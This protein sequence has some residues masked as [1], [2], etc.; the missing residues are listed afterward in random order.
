MCINLDVNVHVIG[1]QN[2]LEYTPEWKEWKFSSVSLQWTIV[3]KCA[4]NSHEKRRILT[5][6]LHKLHFGEY[7]KE[8]SKSP[9]IIVKNKRNLFW[10]LLV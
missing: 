2:T 5:W 10:S 7:G 1:K 8:E 3:R 4:N 6:I 9:K